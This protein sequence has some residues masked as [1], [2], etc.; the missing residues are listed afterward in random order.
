M[1]GRGSTHR[2]VLVG[3]GVNFVE[4]AALAVAAG[5]SG[6]VALRA[7]TATNAADVAVAAFLLVGVLMIAGLFGD[8]N[9]ADKPLLVITASVALC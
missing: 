8:H 9:A 2:A 7:A 3:L 1:S 4:A 5:V 6:S